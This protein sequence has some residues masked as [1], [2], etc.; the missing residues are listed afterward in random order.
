MDFL[1]RH[2]QDRTDWILHPD[3]F[4]KINSRWGPLEIDL[5]TSRFSAQLPHFYS[6][7][8]DPEAVATDAFM[9]RWTGV[10]AFA[11]PP[12]CLVS[13]VLQKVRLER[14]PLV[15]ITPL[16]RTQLSFLVTISMLIDHPLLLPETLIP[17]PNCEY[18]V[19]FHSRIQLVAWSVSGRTNF[20][21]R[22]IPEEA[23]ELLLS[24]WR[25]KT[26]SNYNP[27]WKK[28]D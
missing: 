5:F 4:A 28:W 7:R 22:N 20:R 15:L 19:D 23:I 12:W 25:E 16:W 18:L 14:G 2:L 17:S 6:W 11:H 26:N 9:Q 27:A 10:I 13:R 8:A 3:L 21:A 24:S 1:S